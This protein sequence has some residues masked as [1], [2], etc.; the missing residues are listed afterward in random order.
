MPREQIVQLVADSYRTVVAELGIAIVEPVSE[1]T[2]LVGPDSLLDSIALVSVVLDIEQR[3]EEE[4]N[5]KVRLMDDRALSR[6][7]S[8]FRTIGTLVEYVTEVNE[9]PRS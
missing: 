9:A 8:P 2:A 3:L 1:S 7:H 5:V 6:R 4:V